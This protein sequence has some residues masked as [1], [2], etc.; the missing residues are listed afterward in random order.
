MSKPRDPKARLERARSAL[1]FD[2]PFF[3][4]LALHLEVI[5]DETIPTM[6]T[7]GFRLLWN[8]DFVTSLDDKEIMG[9]LAH[10]VL[11]NAYRHHTRRQTRDPLLWNVAADF[12]INRDLLDAKFML[13]KGHLH[14]KRFGEA[15]AEEIYAILMREGKAAR[16]KGGSDPGG[17]GVVMDA[18]GSS[19]DRAANDSKWEL[20]T[21]Q[22]L[23]VAKAAGTLP[24]YLKR[25]AEA[26]NKP[27]VDWRDVLRRFI[28]DV[29][30]R[31]Y[32]WTRPN[33]R[34]VG[35]GVILPGWIADGVSKIVC[36]VDTSGS[37]SEADLI[38]FASEIR[39]VLDDGAVS[40]VIVIYADARVQHSET[41][42]AGDVVRLDA[43]GG[44]GT[45]FRDT[46]RVISRDH[47]DAAAVVYLTDLCVSQFGE[48]PACPVLWAQYGPQSLAAR[49]PFGEIV[50]IGDG[51]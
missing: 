17:C 16:F 21:R 2:Q 35:Q 50:H 38:Q 12:A 4:V 33:R 51:A 18:P 13:P 37:I 43:K 27:R 48:E 3:G 41:F 49:P 10:E 24:G 15:G 9:V 22:A 6:A 11:H 45:D 34:F 46:F 25:L 20:A 28:D 36:A 40:S 5:Q 7:D 1:I 19:A 30:H 8:S 42:E 44:G 47:Q 23:A 39:G 31:D 32:S 26:L 14:D 29:S